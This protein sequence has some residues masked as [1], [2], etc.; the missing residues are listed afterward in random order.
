[1]SARKTQAQWDADR[2]AVKEAAAVTV[3]A[4][5]EAAAAKKKAFQERTFDSVAAE[6]AAGTS[7]GEEAEAG[8]YDGFTNDQLAEA[9]K[10]RG[11]PHTG[12]K[13]E[14]I[15]RLTEADQAAE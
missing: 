1:M 10:E 11:L 6:Q 4:E 14:L 7:A 3:K 5:A 9:L 13:G 2:A 12:N 15:A 8:P